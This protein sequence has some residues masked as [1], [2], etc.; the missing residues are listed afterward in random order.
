LDPKSLQREDRDHLIIGLALRRLCR[1][2]VIAPRLESIQVLLL[3]AF[4]VFR[5]QA[6]VNTKAE[7][8][9]PH[10]TIILRRIRRMVFC[11]LIDA[12]NLR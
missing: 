1:Q 3:K 6:G 9:K 7:V 10:S 5:V 4:F 12:A 2:T 11:G 8:V